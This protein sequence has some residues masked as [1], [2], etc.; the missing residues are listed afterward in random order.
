MKQI[1]VN[2][3]QV[4]EEARQIWSDRPIV[5]AS[6]DKVKIAL[7]IIDAQNTFCHPDYP[8]LLVP[9]A[10]EDNT[11]LAMFIKENI[12]ILTKIF[13]SLDTHVPMQI[14]FPMF[15]VDAMGHH[16][17]PY[18]V[19]T[20]NDVDDGKWKI[21]PE[22]GRVY[23]KTD[24]WLAE[25]ACWY[26]YHTTLII[27][28]YHA[29]AGSFGHA[30]DP[31]IEEAIFLHELVRQTHRTVAQKGM[32]PFS[33]FYSL[34]VPQVHQ[35]HDGTVVAE[36]NIKLAHQIL[37]GCDRLVI[38]GQAKSHCLAESVE[39]IVQGA[40]LPGLT[41]NK[42]AE[43]RIYLLDDCTSPVEGFEAQGEKAFG[44]FAEAGVH[45][46]ESTTPMNEWPGMKLG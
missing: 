20:P 10:W 28:P 29:L 8:E 35:A 41:A 19:I 27:W 31:Q 37:A 4:Q 32:D 30:L 18:T 11:R 9:G 36:L 40:L 2:R 38:A 43:G 39:S 17:D 6:E 23:G 26:V 45:I 33:E 16:P 12:E 21:N 44:R 25:Y 46:V 42:L 13:A 5:T 7:L 22:V 3:G 1:S 34:F 24:Q 15:W 14:F